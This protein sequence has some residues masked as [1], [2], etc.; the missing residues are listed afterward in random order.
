KSISDSNNNHQSKHHH[1]HHNH[2]KKSTATSTV[3]KNTTNK[4]TMRVIAQQ[5][6]S[7]KVIESNYLPIIHKESINLVKYF[8]KNA[9]ILINPVDALTHSIS[10]TFSLITFG[11]SAEKFSFDF[12]EF[13]ESANALEQKEIQIES[14]QFLRKISS[15]QQTLENKVHLSKTKYAEISKQIVGS[16]KKTTAKNSTNDKCF[17]GE[18]L[19]SMK[20]KADEKEF[21]NLSSNLLFNGIENTL[22]ELKPVGFFSQ[23]YIVTKDDIYQGY[24]IPQNANVI[25][26]TNTLHFNQTLFERAKRFSPE[27]Y[28]DEQ[29]HLK[30]NPDSAKVWMFGKG[31]NAS[32]GEYLTEITLSAIIAHTLALFIITPEIDET[33]GDEKEI[34]ME[35]VSNGFKLDAPNYNVIFELRKDVDHEKIFRGNY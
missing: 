26:N 31:P 14:L 34:N 4:N 10:K 29:G 20:P 27:R 16:L 11:T 15:T 17:T 13:L 30:Q 8:Y 25:F 28:L 9:G 24:H 5:A 19:K 18:I 2:N 6:L 32:I 22:A 33:T 21:L 23:P 3:I 7:S 1:H 35:G 12:T